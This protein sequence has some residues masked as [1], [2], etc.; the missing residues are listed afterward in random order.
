MEEHIMI[1]LGA[2]FGLLV[3]HIFVQPIMDE[4][5]PRRDK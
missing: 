5:R 3:F 2:I 1:V 4:L